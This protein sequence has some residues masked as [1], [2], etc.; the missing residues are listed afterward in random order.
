[1]TSLLT[2]TQLGPQPAPLGEVTKLLWGIRAF[3]EIREVA[4][5]HRG[6]HWALPG[7]RRFFDAPDRIRT[8]SW[9]HLRRS[10]C[11]FVGARSEDRGY[12]L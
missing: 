10:A 7:G 12:H 9:P 8:Q 5:L 2:P 6:A 1:M 4:H 3:A 11:E